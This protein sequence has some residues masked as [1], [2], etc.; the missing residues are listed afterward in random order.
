MS[1]AMGE[2]LGDIDSW[3]SM[4]WILRAFA[5]AMNNKTAGGLNFGTKRGRIMGA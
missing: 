5:A 3:F 2:V 4:L 1:K